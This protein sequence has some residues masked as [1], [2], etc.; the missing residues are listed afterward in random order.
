MLDAYD[1]S[2]LN[3]TNKES[4]NLARTFLNVKNP[5]NFEEKGVDWTQG[6]NGKSQRFV[7]YN[8]AIG[9][10]QL[11]WLRGTL[12]AALDAQEKC[13]VLSHV[14]LIPGACSISCVVWNYEEVLPI[15]HNPAR[16]SNNGATSSA[17]DSGINEFGPTP[18]VCCLYGHAHKGG[19]RMDRRGIHH[20]T[21]QA[22]LEAVGDELAHATIDLM[23]DHLVIRGEGRVTSHGKL[24]Y[25]CGHESINSSYGVIDELTLADFMNKTNICDRAHAL[26]LLMQHDGILSEAQKSVGSNL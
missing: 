12:L 4:T 2:M 3:G 17:T 22:P 11:N 9:K 6:L 18:V 1:I 8:G 15:L 20:I 25:P 7:P 23:E 21:L 10:D 19:Y 14:S 5:N 24:M 16:H 26:D 13:V